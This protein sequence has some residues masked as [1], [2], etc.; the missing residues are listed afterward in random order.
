GI[1]EGHPEYY[2]EEVEWNVHFTSGGLYVHSAPWS[3]PSQG[4]ANVSH[5][6]VNASPENAEWFF[7]FSRYGDIIDVRNTGRP[8]DESQLGND[9]AFSWE[10]WVAGSALP[11]GTEVDPTPIGGSP[12]AGAG[13]VTATTAPAAAPAA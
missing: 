2:Y 4:S 10:D 5:G 7:N 3:V 13:G 9:W 6:C 12:L 1:P 11:V 8:P